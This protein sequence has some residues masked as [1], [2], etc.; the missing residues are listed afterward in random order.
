MILKDPKGQLF[1][2]E[3]YGNEPDDIQ[4][5]SAVYI[6]GTEVPEDVLD[7]AM[8]YYANTIYQEWVEKMIGAAENYRDSMEDR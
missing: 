7:W 1:E 8:S 5:D 2:L 6:D 4:A 3:I